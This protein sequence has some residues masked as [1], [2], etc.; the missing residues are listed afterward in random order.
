MSAQ[1]LQ[2]KAHR[3]TDD[4]IVQ[5]GA[6]NPVPLAFHAQT[7]AGAATMVD[8]VKTVA[9][10]GTPEALGSG[11]VS[12]VAIYPLR[13]NN[14]RVYW[15]GSATNDTQH[16]WTPVRL[17]APPGKKLNLAQIF[18]DVMTAGDGVR[19]STAD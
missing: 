17:T 2:C 16:G 18:L 10:P 7:S 5:S 14:D 9:S 1:P 8:T 19:F 4:S 11:L 12:E 3:G 6:A 15:G 13:T